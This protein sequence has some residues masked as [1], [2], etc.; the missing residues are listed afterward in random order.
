M[1]N[2]IFSILVHEC[3]D[4][5]E[6]QIKNIHYFNPN[7]E[8]VLHCNE[9]IGKFEF[10]N[11]ITNPNRYPTQWGHS[12]FGVHVSNFLTVQD[13]EFEY[14]CMLS[15][16]ELFFRTGAYDYMKQFDCGIQQ[17]DNCSHQYGSQYGRVMELSAQTGLHPYTS[18]IEGVFLKKSIM[19]DL[20][21]TLKNLNFDFELMLQA[22]EEE[23]IFPT[24]LSPNH[25][26]KGLPITWCEWIGGS[27][28]TIDIV[29]QIIRG[30]PVY[31]MYN[32]DSLFSIKRVSRQLDDPLRVSIRE[33]NNY[34][35]C[36]L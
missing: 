18:Q 17:T 25:I 36:I 6:D 12:M 13:Y 2:I 30:E 7:C 11:A 21:Q 16:N 14:I 34:Y 32:V 3:P 27:P 15:S 35:N 28:A 9:Q 26:Y 19:C 20:I 4:V 1:K 31:G 29:D 22:C 23:S 24:M 5:V 10:D 33:R 8:I